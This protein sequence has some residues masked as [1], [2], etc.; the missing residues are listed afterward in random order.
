MQRAVGKQ[1]FVVS[2]VASAQVGHISVVIV[3]EERV[4]AA[5]S[6][7]QTGIAALTVL[8]ALAALRTVPARL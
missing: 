6:A 7:G 5:L 2:F 3:C 4:I 8:V 1:T